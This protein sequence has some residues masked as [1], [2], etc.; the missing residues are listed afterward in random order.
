[1]NLIKITDLTRQLS[2][3]SRTLRYYEQVGLIESIRLPSETYRYYDSFSVQ[4]LQQIIILRKMQIPVKEILSIYEN[5]EISTLVEAFTAKIAEIDKEVT[6]LSE[7]KDIINTFL[8]KMTEKGIKKISAL[9]LLY[10]EMEKQG[11]LLKEQGSPV[12][13]HLDRLQEQ[14]SAPLDTAILL[15]PPMRVLTS[16]LKQSPGESDNTGFW[17]TVQS[18]GLPSGL[19][20][21][22]EQFE[23][24][25]GSQGAVMLRIEEGFRNDTDYLD[26]SFPGG[27][28]GCAN[29]YADQDVEEQFRRLVKSFD[30]SH[31]YEIDYS[32]EGGLRR[33]A[34]I[35]NL[36]S[37]DESRE[38]VSIL[39][40]KSVV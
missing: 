33:H 28:Y 12:L 36:I 27:L 29:V 34:L 11:E 39:D 1:M 7:L 13:H 15:L 37:P 19:P 16:C 20:G 2:L 14:L 31:L 40:R 5:P 38:L 10:E 17:H 9:P 22:H 24:Q 30:D 35:E 21:S 8:Q 23:F 4:R 6:A 25:N 3:S 26:I 18:L 32:H